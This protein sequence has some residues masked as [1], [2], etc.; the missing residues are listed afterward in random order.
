MLKR[1]QNICVSVN[2]NHLIA[3]SNITLISVN[4]IGCWMNLKIDHWIGPGVD[5]DY[6]LER[7]LNKKNLG[8]LKLLA[9]L[10]TKLSLSLLWRVASFLNY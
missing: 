10:F 3:Y 1:L 5:K 9:D 8:G 6:S 4:F 7:W 2:Q